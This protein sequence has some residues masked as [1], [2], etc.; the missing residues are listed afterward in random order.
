V[1]SE[2]IDILSMSLGSEDIPLF[3]IDVV[4]LATFRAEQRN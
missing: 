1:V 2:D 3:Y 4:A